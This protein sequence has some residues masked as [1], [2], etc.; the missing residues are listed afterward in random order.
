M[1]RLHIDPG[2]SARVFF[3]LFAFPDEERVRLRPPRETAPA[4]G[5]FFWALRIFCAAA[6]SDLFEYLILNVCLVPQKPVYG[7]PSV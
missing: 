7:H 5:V 2:L 4:P 1:S 6:P 3:Q